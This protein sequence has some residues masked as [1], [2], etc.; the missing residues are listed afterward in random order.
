MRVNRLAFDATV[1]C[2]T[3]CAIGEVGG[4]V[5]S[6]ALGMGNAQSI[7]LATVLAFVFG[8]AFSFVPLLR[9]GMAAGDALRVAIGGDTVSIAV[10]ELTDNAVVL[11][12]PGA[13]E[14]GLG[15]VLFWGSLV[16]SLALAF[17]AAYPVNVWLVSTGRRS[18]GAHG[19]SRE[20]A[21]H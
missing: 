2:L 13:M 6:T 3:G 15:D 12:I 9:A 18:H 16:L 4:L 7:G 20:H 1:H 5:L 21:H 8:Y 17:A 10:M 14:A 19:P 11:A